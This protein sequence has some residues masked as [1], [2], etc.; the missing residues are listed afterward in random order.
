LTIGGAPISTA[1]TSSDFP[2]ECL[3]ISATSAG[4]SRVTREASSMLTLVTI[5][6]QHDLPGSLW[7][8]LVLRAS[9]LGA[10]Y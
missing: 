2:K 8:V 10:L 5:K 7:R 4:F 9:P 1:A 3:S 6:G